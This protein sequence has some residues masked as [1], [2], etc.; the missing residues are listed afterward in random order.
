M[1]E[2]NG[3]HKFLKF[4]YIRDNTFGVLRS[5][6]PSY[7]VDL[8][9]A[10][11]VNAKPTGNDSGFITYSNTANFSSKWLDKRGYLITL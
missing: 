10:G 9:C 1:K 6:I 4:P 11:T 7:E 3:G 8:E 5:E 2:D